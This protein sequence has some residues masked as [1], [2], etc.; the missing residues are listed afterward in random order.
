MYVNTETSHSKV[1]MHRRGMM[2]SLANKQYMKKKVE[3]KIRTGSGW[4][5]SVLITSCHGILSSSLFI[6]DVL[7]SCFT[8]GVVSVA[9]LSGFFSGLGTRLTTS[10][11]E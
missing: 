6:D 11:G 8:R 2:T 4:L 1:M 3:M 5:E 10:F 9:S 7:L